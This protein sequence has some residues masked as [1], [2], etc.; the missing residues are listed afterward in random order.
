MG[1][2]RG[3]SISAVQTID[4]EGVTAEYNTQSEVQD[5]IWSEVHQSYY[6]LAEEVP[7]CQGQMREEFGYTANDKAAKDVLSGQYQFREDFDTAMQRI[8]EAI[9]DTR[10]VVSNDSVE[11]IITREI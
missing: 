2:K 8:M 9:V 4:E 3:T 5:A 11:K 1:K 10:T 7:I 6:H